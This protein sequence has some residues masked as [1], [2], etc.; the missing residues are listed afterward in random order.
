MT[1]SIK[2]GDAVKAKDEHGVERN[3]IVTNVWPNPATYDDAGVV[4]LNLNIVFVSADESKN[5]SYG[6]QTEHQTSCGHRSAA[7]ECPGRFWWQE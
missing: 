5:D 4:T 1:R 3:A 7:G 2:I 6:R